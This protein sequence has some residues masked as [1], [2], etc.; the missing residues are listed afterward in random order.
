MEAVQP[1][2]TIA[3]R[4]VDEVELFADSRPLTDEELA[5]YS[6]RTTKRPG[7]AFAVLVALPFATEGLCRTLE[8]WK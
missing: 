3:T 1:L 8:H 2:H 7:L 5:Q 6:R 4:V